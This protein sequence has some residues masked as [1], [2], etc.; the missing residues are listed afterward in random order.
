MKK[1]LLML[2]SILL[3]LAF[4]SPTVEAVDLGNGPSGFDELI[5]PEARCHSSSSSSHHRCRFPIRGPTGP[6][7]PKGRPGRSVSTAYASFYNNE[8]GIV[9]P[10]TN[11]EFP[12]NAIL[13]VGGIS[14]DPTNPTTTFNI[15]KPGTYLINFGVSATSDQS[16]VQLQVNGVTVDSGI[17]DA[18]AGVL[19][20]TSTMV[21]LTG[22]L[23]Q[24][25]VQTGSSST[26]NLTGPGSAGVVVAYITFQRLGQ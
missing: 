17:L 12:N 8:G 2:S 1:R 11:L 3:Q 5:G 10:S 23:N 6:R 16:F 13:P 22:P 26:V 15:T 14:R 4:V 25:T 24:I 7:G 21:T 9:N 20:S 19:E 18:S